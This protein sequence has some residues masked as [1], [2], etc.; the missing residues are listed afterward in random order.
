MAPAQQQQQQQ[1]GQQT[2]AI[3]QQQQQRQ[4]AVTS[5]QQQQQLQQGQQAVPSGQQQQRQ[6]RRQPALLRCLLLLAVAAAAVALMAPLGVSASPTGPPGIDARVRGEWERL[7]GICPDQQY[8]S[9]NGIDRSQWTKADA[10][11]V[12]AVAFGGVGAWTTFKLVTYDTRGARKTRGGDSWVVVIRDVSQKL[13]AAARVFDDG[14]G[15]Y[16]VYAVLHGPGV[17]TLHAWLWYSVCHGLQE[18]VTTATLPD[19]ESYERILTRADHC[20]IGE[21]LRRPLLVVGKM[22]E[23]PCSGGSGS[24]SC[25][26]A[27]QSGGGAGEESTWRTGAY[28]L[29]RN[30]T[31]EC[32]SCC[33]PPFPPPGAPAPRAPSRLIFYG[34]STVKNTWELLLYSARGPCKREWQPR[35]IQELVKPGDADKHNMCTRVDSLAEVDPHLDTVLKRCTADAPWTSAPVGTNN[36]D[37][38]QFF[39]MASHMDPVSYTSPQFSV[40]YVDGWGCKVFDGYVD[41]D[42]EGLRAGDVLVANIGAHCQRKMLFGDWRT[43]MDKVAKL[44]SDVRT[45]T[46]ATLVWRTTFPIEEDVF[47]THRDNLDGYVPQAHFNTDARRVMF[48]S[49]AEAVMTA[50]G[51]HVWDVSGLASLG[52]YKNHDMFHVDAPTMWAMNTDMMSL[53]VCP[54]AR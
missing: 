22:G 21:T 33:R 8:T 41:K 10:T 26:V 13:K 36:A 47:R 49:Y 12:E 16:T 52:N 14:D 2:V 43:H 34:D 39:P 5:E 31:I 45:R 6:Q 35:D 19:F 53:F 15:S 9:C 32:F 48:D 38:L 51:V 25:P 11:Q 46:G 37:L 17:Y 42:F 4:Q 3:G 50:A 29:R 18:P 23:V 30:R 20:F 54:A 7:L 1:Q 24:G 28:H 40:M 27:A 44:L